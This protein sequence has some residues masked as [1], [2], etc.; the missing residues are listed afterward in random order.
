MNK[1][2]FFKY[3]AGFAA[4]IAVLM[5]CE[6]FVFRFP[7]ELL[8][9][10]GATSAVFTDRYGEPLRERMS[11]DEK[12]A[13]WIGLDE[14]SPYVPLA[15]I[16]AEDARFYKHHGVDL[17]AIVRALAQNAGSGRIVSGGSTITQQLVRNIRPARR[18]IVN[19][20]MEAILAVRLERKLSKKEILYQYLN[21]IPYGNG[22][23]GIGSA[24]ETYFNK[25]AAD[26][27]LSESAFLAALPQAPSLY[28]P[29]KNP[30][31]AMSRYRGI[32][33]KMLALGMIGKREYERALATEITT[34][35]TARPFLAPHFTDYL[36]AGS[37]P[38]ILRKAGRIRTTI[39]LDLQR[40]LEGI[41]RSRLEGLADKRVTN[42]AAVIIKNDTGE[43]LAFVG[44]ADYFSRENAGMNDGA[45]AK[46]QPGSALK[47]FTYAAALENGYTAATVLPDI[48][49]HFDTPD[50]DYTPK[51]YDLKYNGPVRLRLA[52][53][54]SLNVPAVAVAKKIG[55]SVIIDYLRRLGISSLDKGAGHYGLGVTLGN[56]EV[57]LMQLSHAYTVFPNL[58]ESVPLRGIISYTE[59]GRGERPYPAAPGGRERIFSQRTAYIIADIL[60]DRNSRAHTFGL[61]GPLT[62]PFK[63]GA[64]TGTSSNFRDN[65]TIGFTGEITV[66]VWCGNFSGRPMENVSGVTGAGPIF[67]DAMRETMKKFDRSWLKKP[68]GIVVRKICP[69][70]GLRPGP[71][72]LGEVDEMFAAGKEPSGKCTYHVVEEIDIRNGLL[73][74]P[75]CEPRY[76]GEKTSV[77]Y[78]AEYSAWAASNGVSRPVEEYSPLCGYGSYAQQHAKSILILF[79]GDGDVFGVDPDVPKE[80][81][82]IVFRAAVP[83]GVKSLSWIVDGKYVGRAGSP[84][85]YPWKLKKGRHAISA[86][87][88]VLHSR[89][90]RINVK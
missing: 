20:A 14:V 72:C 28:D 85:S 6:M 70:S 87:A 53:A 76:V 80:Y 19:K 74:G 32:L 60:S 88:G 31:R 29:F 46:R 65:W 89:D 22:A 81:G 69:L 13:S 63:V 18:N 57:S 67:R 66:G 49:S 9:T 68:D 55:P 44:S 26:L 15:A 8:D 64:K 7:D 5:F 33:K 35:R 56:G 4:F 78:P 47:P 52:L 30:G 17:K 40:T 82:S 23:Y 90:I 12:R 45:L 50:G 37:D 71:A 48:E 59:P 86:E 27:T 39:D 34:D 38:A 2:N 1:I 79:P 73:A 3:G 10:S 16:A 43:I 75:K 36:I 51:N 24:A 21:R 62:L 58:G 77:R 25:K 41:V 61:S 84:F 42:A 83:A 54:N 11:A